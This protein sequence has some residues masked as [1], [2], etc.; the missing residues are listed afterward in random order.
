MID[1]TLEGYSLPDTKVFVTHFIIFLLYI[2]EK[3]FLVEIQIDQ[4]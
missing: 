1:K 3:I 2:N 4:V